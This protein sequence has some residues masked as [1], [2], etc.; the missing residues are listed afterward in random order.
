MWVRKNE[1]GGLTDARGA[2]ATAEGLLFWVER[3]A[4]DG[5]FGGA[6]VAGDGEGG[7]GG[8]SFGGHCDGKVYQ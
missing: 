8:G 6:A 5:D 4:R 7:V 1:D 2:V 3:V